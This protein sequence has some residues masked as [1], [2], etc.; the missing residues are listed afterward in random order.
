MKILQQRG[1]KGL[2]VTCPK[3]VSLILVEANDVLFATTN[4]FFALCGYCRG[5]VLL[6]ADALPAS[7]TEWVR[8]WRPQPSGFPPNPHV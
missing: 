8:T 1:W 4:T 2:E 7:I 6:Q 5:V 3:C